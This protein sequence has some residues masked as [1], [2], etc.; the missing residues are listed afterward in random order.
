[1]AYTTLTNVKALISKAV[2]AT[3]IGD[4]N[5]PMT[6]VQADQIVVNVQGEVDTLLSSQGVV[7]EVTTP[8][9]FVSALAQLVEYGS[10]ARILKSILPDVTGPGETPAYMYWE[11]LYKQGRKD[12]KDGCLIPLDAVMVGATA[13]APGSTAT[14]LTEYPEENPDQGANAAPK[15]VKGKVW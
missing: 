3:D 4:G 14:H 6:T 15:I 9:H 10:A 5:S 1:M 2:K 13:N 12:I 11:N 8:A 7:V